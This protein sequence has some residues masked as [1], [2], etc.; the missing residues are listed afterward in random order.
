MTEKHR[1][2][3][4]NFPSA[5]EEASPRETEYPPAYRL[6]FNDQDFLLRE[7]LR[8][9]RFHLELQKPE[10]TLKEHGVDA[11]I[12]IFGSA[13]Y[14]SPDQA[15]AASAAAEASGDPAVIRRAKRDERNSHYYDQARRL[16]QLV[17]EHSMN[18]AKP[19][20]IYVVTGGGPGIMEAANRGAQD[21][22][23]PSIGLNIVLPHE[24]APNPYIS[25]EFCFRFHYFGIR[26][27]H[28]MLR[29]K[30]VVVFPGGFGTFDELF[31]ALTLIQTG[32]SRRVP[33]L[34]VG[35]EFW[36]KAINLEFLRDEG[37]ISPEDVNM[38]KVVDNAD[39][40][41]QEIIDFYDLSPGRA[42]SC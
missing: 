30:A 16:G 7:E 29:A 38:I 21:A 28:F 40:A 23:G 2:H 1:L 10:M 33:V 14:L 4:A 13:R 25:P 11:T 36:G 32:K 42:P 15:K 17:T 20:Q 5:R 39:S 37:V 41:W 12:A 34:L 9:L 26:K 22:G 3:D 24:Q 19:E 27:M 8:G 6:A 18:C 35:H 31:E